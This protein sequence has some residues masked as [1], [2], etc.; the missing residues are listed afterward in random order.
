LIGAHAVV[1]CYAC[2]KVG[3]VGQFNRFGLSTECFSCHSTAFN[4][5]TAPKH[6]ALGFSTDCREC[7]M[8]MDSWAGATLT[9][10]HRWR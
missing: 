7:H 5:A 1:D 3:T 9:P 4:S 2:H 8:S 6:R 10:N